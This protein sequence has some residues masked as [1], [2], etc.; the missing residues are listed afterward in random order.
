ML[1]YLHHCGECPLSWCA[2]L[3]LRAVKGLEEEGRVDNGRRWGGGGKGGGEGRGALG[4]NLTVK[5]VRMNKLNLF[6]T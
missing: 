1:A 3:F 2:S 5:V 6:G 4:H